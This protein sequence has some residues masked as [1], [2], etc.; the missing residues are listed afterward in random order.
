MAVKADHDPTFDAF[1]SNGTKLGRLLFTADQMAEYGIVLRNH[2]G[3][4][5]IATKQGANSYT[6]SS[7]RWAG[8]GPPDLTRGIT[9]RDH[10]FSGSYNLQFGDSFNQSIVRRNAS[11]AGWDLANQ[12]ACNIFQYSPGPSYSALIYADN[13][14]LISRGQ[15]AFQF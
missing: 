13:G 6:I 2:T 10:Y 1:A 3:H 8:S 15:L 7:F 12:F 9:K 14:T 5:V 4:D 11:S